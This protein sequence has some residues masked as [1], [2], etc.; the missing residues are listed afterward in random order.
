QVA[1]LFVLSLMRAILF[2]LMCMRASVK[3]HDRLFRSVV[4]APIA[5]FD[6][7]PI[8]IILNRC[9]RDMGIID[10]LLPPTAFDAFGIL[11][12]DLGIT[13][14]IAYIDYW[15]LLPT[16]LL[17]VIFYYVRK[18]YVNTAKD[19]KRLEGITRSPLFSHLSTSLNGLATIRA[20]NSQ[21]RFE[22]KF[23][24]IQDCHTSAWFLYIASSRWFIIM[25]DWICVCYITAITT[26]M[27]LNMHSLNGSFIAL[28]I[29]SAL[30][31][32]GGFQWGIRQLTEMETQM[33]SVE[34]VDEYSSL[35]SEGELENTKSLKAANLW[36][37]KGEIIF[38]NVCLK[39][40]EHEV[41]KSLTF[42][43]S[44]K[45]KIGIVGRTGAGKSSIIAALFRL[46]ESEGL[47]IID[48]IDIKT[49]GLH[50]LRSKIAIIPQDPVLFSGTVRK[51]LDP[52]NEKSDDK[53]WN[54]LIQVQLE[55]VISEL[56][57]GLETITSNDGCNFSVGQRQLICLARA[58]LREN[59][60]LIL[61]E[62]TANVDPRTDSL[63]QE[64]IR[65]VFCHC[66]IITIAH[67]LHTI[68]DSDKVLVLDAGIIKQFDEP[69]EL[70]KDKEGLF[71][72]MVKS[73]GK[74][75]SENLHKM[76]QFAHESRLNEPRFVALQLANTL[77]DKCEYVMD[78]VIET[79]GEKEN[80]IT[81][82]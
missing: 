50:D 51:N 4:R 42:K 58:I 70:L 76:A 30:M 15:I 45:E 24:S 14:L 40:G 9:S 56:P 41:L 79:E 8:G 29:T 21:V 26:S 1:V 12:N 3:L 64:T 72:T 75:M 39:Y 31:F 28:A 65:H 36:P 7:N 59:R 38:D 27:I 19:I 61:D 22:K 78:A 23:D 62:A 55:K 37:E 17:V 49:I 48:G 32:S 33:T 11:S 54:A 10:D 18:L 68:M 44:A 25:L 71:Y 2:F 43:I 13:I 16:L 82:F 80:E 5:F 66:T 57:K 73:T 67:R 34:R 20:F 60:I 35:P 81:K 47:I 69:F 46:T 53:L 77:K 52:F 74:E 63:I 6:N